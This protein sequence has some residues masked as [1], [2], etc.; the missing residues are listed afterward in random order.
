M[1]PADLGAQPRV[2]TGWGR[3]APTTADVVTP[4]LTHDVDAALQAAGERGVLA[5]GLGRAYGDAAQNAGGLVVDATSLAGVRSFDPATGEVTLDAGVSVDALLRWF[6]PRGWF[7]PVTAGT[8]FVTI[9]GAIAADIHGKNHHA[10]GTF[11]MHVRSLVLHTPEGACR[12]GPDEDADV[13]WATVGGMGLTGI[14]TEATVRLL[15]IETAWMRVDTERTTDLDDA[16]A[17]MA[18]GDDR[19]RYSV[20][21][22]DTLSGGRAFGRCV[23]TR[24]DH[25]TPD[26]LDGARR[27]RPLAYDAD[28][29][30][31]AP[32]GV[33]S[34]L[35]RPLTARLLNEVW[36]R[37]TWRDTFGAVHSIPA[38][39]HP[40][41]GIADWNRMYGSRG[42]L[43]YQFAVPPQA[44][45]VI[46]LALR[47]LSEA[48]CPSVLAVL[49]RFGPANPAPLS[50]PVPGWTLAL[51]IPVGPP[52]LPTVL[53]ELDEAVVAAGGRLYLAKDSRMRPEL[54]AAMYPRLD[55]WRAVCG[56]VDPKGRLQS[57][58]S[59]RLG[60]RS[61]R[62]GHA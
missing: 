36:Y 14:I 4:V 29:R 20:A 17:R 39:F 3:T 57:D 11:G 6:V 15:P 24:G 26:D 53:D 50:F 42:F 32:P 55:E 46:R 38:F 2:L 58:L 60:L 30:I 1:S 56:R 28:I 27:Q 23:L 13:F 51:D 19:Y 47:R 48:R 35:V 40:L 54:L 41:D 49:K 7:V 37:K 16:L 44:T 22:I 34:G 61:G 59:R 5:R 45:D 31:S 10:D 52:A 9:G 12:V 18:A 21:W 25:A 62:P 33:P 8:R 43:Q